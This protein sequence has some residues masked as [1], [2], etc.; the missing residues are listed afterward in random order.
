MTVGLYHFLSLGLSTKSW[1]CMLNHW[2]CTQIMERKNQ[3]TNI[4]G[5]TLKLGVGLKT[6]LPCYLCRSERWQKHTCETPNTIIQ[7]AV[8]KPEI[9]RWELSGLPG[10]GWGDEVLLHYLCNLAHVCKAPVSLHSNNTSS[11]VSTHV[12]FQGHENIMSIAAIL[13]LTAQWN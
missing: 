12:S 11:I 13:F 9:P 10:L 7:T 1:D 4:L 6:D 3:T 8:W 5:K 2:R